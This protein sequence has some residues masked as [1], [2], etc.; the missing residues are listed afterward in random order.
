MSKTLNVYDTAGSVIGDYVLE[1]KFIE[2]EKGYQAVHD[3]V[4]AYQAGLRAGTACTKTKAEVRGGG[5]KPFRQKGTGRARTGSIRNPIWTGGGTIFGP[6]PRS[7]AKKINKKVRTL[8]VKRAFSERVN[9]ESVL[10]LNELNL[11]DCKTKNAK[12]I[13]DNLKADR[14]ALMIVDEYDENSLRATG[15]L[16]EVL[17]IKASSVN[18]YQLLDAH[19]VIFTKDGLEAFVQRFV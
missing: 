9:E 7:F 6:K 18:T 4:I 19:K 12:V 1:D 13:F 11:T 5:I 14:K 2:L 8:A 10:V 16:P 15:N 3:T 17:L